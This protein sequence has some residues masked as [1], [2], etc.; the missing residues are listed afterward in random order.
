[1]RFMIIVKATKESEAEVVPN[2]GEELMAAM[3]AYHE[4]LAKAGALLDGSGLHPSSKGWRI[5]VLRGE[6]HCGGRA[7]RRDQ[8]VD[9]GLYPDP[10]QVAGRGHGMDQALSQSSWRG[11]G[12]RDRGS[13]A[14]R[15]G[16]LC[17]QRVGGAISRDGDREEEV[18][19]RFLGEVMNYEEKFVQSNQH[20]ICAREYSGE[21]NESQT[22]EV[23]N[24]GDRNES[25]D[26]N[27]KREK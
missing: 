7:F 27:K 1:M 22:N 26:K 11:Q 15:V 6:T 21:R 14:V 3:A 9:R 18:V 25:S 12:S 24:G 17:P 10:G 13:P 16:R 20:R 8:G 4:E 23:K 5:Q 2:P 19:A